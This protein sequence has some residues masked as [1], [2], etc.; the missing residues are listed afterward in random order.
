M[1]KTS[2]KEITTDQPHF[3]HVI[4]AKQ[5][6]FFINVNDVLNYKD[7]LFLFV[8]RD[9]VTFYKQTILGPIW[10]ILQPTLTALFQF[11]IFGT[12]AKIPSDGIPYFLFVLA[13]NVLWFYFSD[14]LK[15]TC[16]TYTTHQNMFGKVYF[17]RII[18]PLSNAVSNL[19]KFSVQ[20]LF[21]ICVLT[22]YHYQT[23]FSFTWHPILLTTPLILGFVAL[24]ALGIGMIIAS[25]TTKYRDLKFIINFGI[26]LFMY[27][28]PVVIPTSKAI[29]VL[30]PMGLDNLVYLNPLTSCFELFKFAFLGSGQIDQFGIYYTIIFS[31]CIFLV[32]LII[33][34]RA[35]KKFIDTI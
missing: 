4:A 22:Y 32:G 19:I 5:A 30:K 1:D 23:A 35:E 15:S 31:V 28:T 33:F 17:P 21:F 34:N 6:W 29:E 13:G 3:K 14:S 12:I 2:I 11:I 20:F 24:N 16:E 9:F 27:V 7:L 26:H 25:L 10:F 8:K 18:M